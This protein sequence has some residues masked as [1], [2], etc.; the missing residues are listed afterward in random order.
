MRSGRQQVP[1]VPVKLAELVDWKLEDGA[2]P[3]RFPQPV[4]D[5][6]RIVE[7]GVRK[8][9]VEALHGSQRD[10]DESDEGSTVRRRRPGTSA[11]PDAGQH[12]YSEHQENSEAMNRAEPLERG[13]RLVRPD[14][15]GRKRA[16][17]EHHTDAANRQQHPARPPRCGPAPAAKSDA[18]QPECDAAGEERARRS[19]VV[20]LAPGPVMH[21]RSRRQIAAQR[22]SHLGRLGDRWTAVSRIEIRPQ[23]DDQDHERCGG[24]GYEPHQPAPPLASPKSRRAHHRGGS[25]RKNHEDHEIPGRQRSTCHAEPQPRRIR[26]PPV[27]H[28]PTE[29]NER[30]RQPVR[31]QRLHMRDARDERSA[32]RE[33][34]TRQQ[35]G[36][37]VA[38][39]GSDEPIRCERRERQSREDQQVVR[40]QRRT[41]EPVNR[42]GQQAGHDERFGVGERVGV[43]MKH[44]RVEQM[45]GIARNLVC[46]P[47]QSPRVEPLV[48]IEKRQ[49]RRPRRERPGMNGRK[50]EKQ[51][52][53]QQPPVHHRTMQHGS[54]SA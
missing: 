47:G 11:Q 21:I 18:G 27:S 30:K 41:A 1:C 14:V 13:D 16:E 19:M 51:C 15:E 23:H 7:P 36:P 4:V 46:N 29:S 45:H 24:H 5:A 54:P 12:R 6:S 50:G 2:R 49:V 9:S 39:P 28:Q 52:S 34:R 38:G 17:R 26:H 20:S 8:R 48:V 53:R 35:A 25:K 10:Q 22:S 31:V 42:R 32:E 3:G 37:V 43:R 40:K 33:Q 44:V